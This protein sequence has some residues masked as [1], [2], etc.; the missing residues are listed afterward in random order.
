MDGRS[1]RTVRPERM[2]DPAL[3]EAEHRAALAGLARIHR[4]SGTAGLLSRALGD[5][6]DRLSVPGPA[7]VLDVACGGGD[8]TLA[9]RERA[10]RGLAIDGCDKSETAL[11]R[12]RGAA[13][14]RGLDVRFLAHD[15]LEGALPDG[16]HA[17]VCSL[18]LH[19]LEDDVVVDLLSRMARADAVLVHDLV[20]GAPGRLLARLVPPLLTR[21]RVVHDDAV[22]SVDNAFTVDEI[23]ALAVRAGLRG[24]RV[25]RRWPFRFLLT[26]SRS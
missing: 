26:W 20:R 19:H 6:L 12:A 5:L 21:S 9:L 1:T 16:Y 23:R 7:R 8:L 15:V 13:A 14:R 22:L 10:G 3:D 4:V 24:A 25:T 11:Q 18:F 2:D 17:I